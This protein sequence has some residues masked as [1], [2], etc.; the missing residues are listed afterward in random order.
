MLHVKHEKKP[1]IPVIYQK[2]WCSLNVMQYITFHGMYYVNHIPS[3]K[4]I[5]DISGSELLKGSCGFFLHS[6]PPSTPLPKYTGS[7]RLNS[8]TSW[9]RP[10]LFSQQLFILPLTTVVPVELWSRYS[11]IT[12]VL[13]YPALYLGLRSCHIVGMLGPR[14]GAVHWFN[15]VLVMLISAG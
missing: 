14:R 2:L 7:H 15:R 12:S 11:F 4:C 1:S 5:L 10:S 9:S 3:S 6:V 13:H 8:S